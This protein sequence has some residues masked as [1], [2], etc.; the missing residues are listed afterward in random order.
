MV[1]A[2]VVAGQFYPGDKDNLEK[3]LNFLVPD[4]K[5]KI[6]AIGAIVPHAGYMYSGA[7]AGEVYAR[8]AP[9]STYLIISPNHTG[10]GKRFALSNEPWETPLGN[11][12]I[13]V[14]LLK[15]I[16]DGSRLIE[17]DPEAHIAEHSIEVQLPFIKKT[18]PSADVVPLTVQ[19]GEIEELKEISEAIVLAIK[20]SGR[21]VVIIS[22]SD[23]THYE[24]RETAEKKDKFAIDEILDLNAKNLLSVVEEK[25]IS[26]CG[27]IPTAIM[28]FCAK[29]LGAKYAELVKYS[30]SGDVTGDIRQ[31]VGYAGIVV[32]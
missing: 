5:S 3:E 29:K 18:A 10:Y 1:R 22:S 11:V 28:L 17:E 23:M 19:V 16:R 30:D 27:Y 14:D 15:N 4:I 13:N 24:S 31:V 21:D 12:A 6:K 2:A 8:L 32:S 26:M 9:G 20:T 25:N 7:V